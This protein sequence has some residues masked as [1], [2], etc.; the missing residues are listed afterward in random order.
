MCRCKGSYVGRIYDRCCFRSTWIYFFFFFSSRRRHTR[1]TCDWSSDVCSS[2]LSRPVIEIGELLAFADDR[3]AVLVVSDHGAK[4]IDGGI[5]VN[6]WLLA[7]GYLALA[8]K[9]ARATPFSK[10]KID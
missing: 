9:P 10:L 3:T 6:E 4:R 2:D 5:C 7:N 1:L 8:E